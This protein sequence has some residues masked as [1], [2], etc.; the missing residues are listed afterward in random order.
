MN[1]IHCIV[2]I[3]IISHIQSSSDT[4]N[5]LKI[6]ILESTN[7]HCKNNNEFFCNPY[8]IV[9]LKRNGD[10]ISTS[11]IKC[12]KHPQWMSSFIFH[13][14]L[15]K[16][17]IYINFF[18]Y[19][20]QRDKEYFGAS[21]ENMNFI[22]GFL[23]TGYLGRVVIELDRLPQGTI[24]DWF[25]LDVPSSHR[26]IEFPSC[27]HLRI[28]YISSQC[29]EKKER[30][31]QLD[32]NS[33]KEDFIPDRFIPMCRID[34]VD[35]YRKRFSKFDSE[36][37]L[38]ETDEVN[39]RDPCLMDPN[40][41]YA[42]K[43]ESKLTTIE[44][45]LVTKIIKMTT[46]EK[47][48]FQTFAI[49][50]KNKKYNKES[51]NKF[52]KENCDGNKE[53]L[54]IERINHILRNHAMKMISNSTN[55]YVSG[56][57]SKMSYNDKYTQKIRDGIYNRTLKQFE[58]IE[59]VKHL[60]Q[61]DDD[62]YIKSINKITEVIRDI[63]FENKT[64]NT[65]FVEDNKVLLTS[66]GL[67]DPKEEVFFRIFAL[68]KWN[69]GHLHYDELKKE[70][71]LRRKYFH[72]YEDVK[73]MPSNIIF[74]FL[75]DKCP[76]NYVCLDPNGIVI[77]SDGNDPR[78][79]FKNEIDLNGINSY[80]FTLNNNNNSNINT[81]STNITYDNSDN[82][83]IYND[84]DTDLIVFTKLIND[85]VN[86]QIN[87]LNN[88]NN[89]NKQNK[90]LQKHQKF[91][92]KFDILYNQR[93]SRIAKKKEIIINLVHSNSPLMGEIL[94]IATT[95]SLSTL[96]SSSFIKQ[97][98]S[99][100]MKY[101]Q[102]IHNNDEIYLSHASKI[103]YNI[104][105]CRNKRNNLSFF[106]NE[107]IE[108]LCVGDS[109]SIKIFIEIIKALIIDTLLKHEYFEYND[110]QGKI[111]L[112]KLLNESFCFSPIVKIQFIEDM[113]IVNTIKKMLI[114]IIWDND[115][116]IKIAKK[117]NDIDMSQSMGNIIGNDSP[118]MI[119]KQIN[120]AQKE[121][122][123]KRYILLMNKYNLK[124]EKMN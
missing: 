16:D 11:T 52:I 93:Q 75:E 53:G 22:K 124:L 89:N 92:N 32:T 74:Q 56:D 33:K 43:H 35:I 6:D 67:V 10:K 57:T 108:G 15:C 113:L 110:I 8:A 118:I 61:M 88:E 100:L 104:L 13:P 4:S 72:C 51:Y 58:S 81:N 85:E 111:T 41:D 73:I 102:I 1:T 68:Y 123:K 37:G 120:D 20:T 14:S 30:L 39:E 31:Y 109:R 121:L 99:L 55:P 80:N 62:S 87:Y 27:V 95:N 122:L 49:K 29:K 91:M 24:D 45:A 36:N 112:L 66:E 54:T 23:S 96:S 5:Y 44:E 12:T 19:F 28:S 48:N 71:L 97:E 34:F 105:T 7:L 94:A 65:L 25:M 82:E 116:T 101:M 103:L 46:G 90:V 50:Y 17:I 18:Q 76:D 117:I 59:E 86:Y 114:D 38:M 3:I 107:L 77:H 106:L 83:N 47:I 69:G 2:I 78:I 84:N 70:F 64:Q 9:Q 40:G 115:T 60:D 98:T 63:K 26:N 42:F 119:F 21:P 79:V